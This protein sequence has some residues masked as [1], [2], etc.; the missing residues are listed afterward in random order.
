MVRGFD[1]L[2]MEER[3]MKRISRQ[4]WLRIALATGGMLLTAVS[5]A[6][7]RQASFGVDPFQ[8][9]VNGIDNVLPLS[10]GTVNMMVNLI[11][12][13][14]MLLFYRRYIGV[15]TFV[16]LF[17]LGYAVEFFEGILVGCFASPGMVLRIV[18]LLVGIVITC[19]AAAMYY[20]AKL[21]VTTYDAIPLHVTDQQIKIFGWK[22]PFRAMRIFTDLIC[23]A[24]GVLLGAKAGA[25]TVITALF[26]GPLIAFFRSRVTDPFMARH[27]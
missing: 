20:T 6:F 27:S 12:L 15:S 3:F 17:L 14:P 2:N 26:M 4:L 13:V 18:F 21:G 22:I 7:F 11:L 19:F 9:M 10:Y 5:I 25:G 23:T 1:L 8:C 16:N 24:T